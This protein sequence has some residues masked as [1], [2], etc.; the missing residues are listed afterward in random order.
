[1]GMLL[2]LPTKGSPE[3]EQYGIRHVAK[4]GWVEE[5]PIDQEKDARRLL[6]GRKDR[7]Q[8]ECTLE[9]KVVKRRISVGEWE[10]VE[11]PV[12]EGDYIQDPNVLPVGSVVL[13]TRDAS[14][15]V[16]WERGWYLP[17]SNL[18]MERLVPS[19]DPCWKVLYLPAS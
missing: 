10:N 8:P 9:C 6:E 16:K 1:M 19:L 18:P 4:G 15:Y 11:A 14:V 7:G 12:K 17:G 3:A 2:V 5:L 13:L